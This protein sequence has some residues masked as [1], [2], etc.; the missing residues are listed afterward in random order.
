MSLSDEQLIDR[1]KAGSNPAFGQLIDRYQG[2]VFSICIKVLA[3]REEAE[4]AAQD[5]F[6]KL[7]RR[8]RSFRQDS[9]FS[10]WLYTLTYRTAI[11]HRR[12]GKKRREVQSELSIDTAGG[13][14]AEP[15]QAELA[16]ER[17]EQTQQLKGLL[18]QLPKQDALLMDLFYL[19]EQTVKEI[20][21]ILD[22]SVSNVKTKL[23][24]SREK[25]RKLKHRHLSADS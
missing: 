9:R 23:F 17:E 1:V 15:A 16:L 21:V 6:L 5:V 19:Q 10:T 13:H 3:N 8:I 20:A 18:A 22:M 14:L 25:L 4:E 11:D 2:Y 24:R 7:F 12:Q